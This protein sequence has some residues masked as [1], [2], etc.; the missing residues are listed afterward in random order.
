MISV[1]VS[2]LLHPCSYSVASLWVIWLHPNCFP[3]TCVRQKV[4]CSFSQSNK[5][6]FGTG[7]TEPKLIHV[8]VISRLNLYNNTTGLWLCLVVAIAASPRVIPLNQLMLSSGYGKL[9]PKLSHVSALLP[10]LQYVLQLCKLCASR[11]LLYVLSKLFHISLHTNRNS[12]PQPIPTLR[13]YVFF[14]SASAFM[15]LI[16]RPQRSSLRVAD[17]RPCHFGVMQSSLLHSS[18]KHEVKGMEKRSHGV[19]LC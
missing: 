14:M 7:I 1:S 15:H 17:V 18:I 4:S 3:L 13:L 19:G 10:P 12:K 5:L 9:S 16:N 6:V 8:F 11:F 2:V